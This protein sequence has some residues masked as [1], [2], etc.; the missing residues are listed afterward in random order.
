MGIVEPGKV[1]IVLC[2]D[3]DEAG[4]RATLKNIDML[5]DVRKGRPVKKRELMTNETELQGIIAR[6]KAK[7]DIREVLSDD[8]WPIDLKQYR[9]PVV[10]CPFHDDHQPSLRLYPDENRWWCYSCNI[11]GS[12][13][14][15][16][17]KSK[18][19]GFIP[20]VKYLATKY[21]GLDL[22][23]VEGTNPEE[24]PGQIKYL[25][26]KVAELEQGLGKKRQQ[27]AELEE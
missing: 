11:G 8:G 27:F 17:M 4:Q 16:V 2:L 18:G 15:W 21:L 14:D 7:V 26:R 12:T 10:L 19:I 24:I 20:S 9:N 25:L 23:E 5:L 22:S 6:I 1:N 3:G 13:I